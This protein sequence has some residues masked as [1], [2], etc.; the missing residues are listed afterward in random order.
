MKKRINSRQKGKRGELLVCKL[1]TKTAGGEWRRTAQVR[2]K[3]HG[4]PD[5]ESP[6]SPN[7]WVE[8]KD[9]AGWYVGCTPWIQAWAQCRTEAEEAGKVPVLIWRSARG[10]FAATVGVVQIYGLQAVTY[11]DI[12]WAVAYAEQ[13]AKGVVIQ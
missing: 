4:A 3:N 2:G 6:A 11:G 5:I 12:G 10:K 1:L 7:L 9:R 8:V 13:L